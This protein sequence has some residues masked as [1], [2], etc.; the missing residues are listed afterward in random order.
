VAGDISEQELS[1]GSAVMYESGGTTVKM[2]ISF[3][4]AGD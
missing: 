1:D 3:V 4:D 2:D